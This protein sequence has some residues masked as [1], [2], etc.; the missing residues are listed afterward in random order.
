MNEVLMLV[1]ILVSIALFSIGGM[2][3]KGVR[4]FVLP[5]VLGITASFYVEWWQCVGYAVTLS[6][7]LCLGYGERASW[8]YRLAIFIGYGAV[9]LWFG[10]SWWVLVTPIACAGMFI[11]SNNPLTAQSFVWRI[12]EAGMGF[13]ISA[14]FI[15]SILNNWGLV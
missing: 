9:S 13:L 10:F 6:A 1:V 2:G 5:I 8:L 14:G 11:L 4:R 7:L 12:V 3:W 15:G